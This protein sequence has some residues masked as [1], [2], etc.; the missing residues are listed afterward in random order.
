MQF[1]EANSD[2]NN[3]SLI[4]KDENGDSRLVPAITIYDID[5]AILWQLQNGFKLKIEQNN[6]MIDVPVMMS[7]PEKW[8]QIQKYGG[9]TRTA[10]NK[11]M[12]PLIILK[13]LSLVEDERFQFDSVANKIIYLPIRNT[14]DKFNNISKTDNTNPSYEYLISIIPTNVIVNYDLIIWC[15]QQSQLNSIVEQILPSDKSIWGDVFQFTTNVGEIQFETINNQGED[16]VVRATIPLT[17]NGMLRN[18][19]TANEADVQKAFTIKRVDFK[20]EWEEP[21]FTVNYESR[22][23]IIGP[24]RLKITPHMLSDDINKKF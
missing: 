14:A 10:D 3:K 1:R 12:A 5:Y 6:E 16:R 20:N 4:I 22:P 24:S 8:V 21:D 13:R 15:H 9:V 23:R 18:E 7:S 17:V 2:T 11:L 19:F